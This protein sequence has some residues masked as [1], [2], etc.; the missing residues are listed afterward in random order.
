MAGW[1]GDFSPAGINW[2]SNSGPHHLLGSTTQDQTRIREWL[3]YLCYECCT[4]TEVAQ[5][6]AC[7]GMRSMHFPKRGTAG[8]IN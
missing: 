7:Q 5:S 8:T 6:S 4:D 1:R 2:Y 3:L